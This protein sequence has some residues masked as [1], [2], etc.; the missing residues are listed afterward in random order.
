MGSSENFFNIEVAGYSEPKITT[1]RL[2]HAKTF[3]DFGF[4]EESD[5]TRRLF[6]LMDMLLNK[7]KDMLY[8]VNELERSLTER[9]LQLFMQLYSEECMQ[10]LF[11]TH[12]SSIMDQSIF[13]R[14]EILFIEQGADYSLLNCKKWQKQ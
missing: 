7:R 11:T 10:L 12:E 8:V 6:D 4:E 2:N 1:I 5:G 13:M 3:F 9:F 14:D